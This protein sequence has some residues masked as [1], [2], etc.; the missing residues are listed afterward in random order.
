MSNSNRVGFQRVIFKPP[1]IVSALRT[2]LMAQPLT[3]LKRETDIGGQIVWS[4][5]NGGKG[6]TET[7]GGFE[8]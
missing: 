4:K 8:I 5:G 3:G 2:Q 1:S 6:N 7:E